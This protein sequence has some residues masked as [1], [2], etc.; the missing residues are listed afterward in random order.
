MLKPKT[1]PA[2][3]AAQNRPVIRR[4]TMKAAQAEAGGASISV[5]LNDTTGPSVVVIG[6]MSMATVGEVVAHARL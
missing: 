4:A 2:G 6:H 1:T 3:S 5:R